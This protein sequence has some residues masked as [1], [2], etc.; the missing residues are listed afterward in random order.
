MGNGWLGCAWAL[1]VL[2]WVYLV[3]SEE[4]EQALLRR[5]RRIGHNAALLETLSEGCLHGAFYGATL[6]TFLGERIGFTLHWQVKT[7]AVIV[8]LLAF[9]YAAYE[10]KR[11]LEDLHSPAT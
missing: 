7:L 2:L 9:M 4:A 5:W 11:V 10:I 6:F 3:Y 8:W 1:A